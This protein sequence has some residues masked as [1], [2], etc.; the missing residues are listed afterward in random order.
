MQFQASE[1]IVDRVLDS[2]DGISD[3]KNGLIWHW[4]GSGKTLT[5][6][7]AANKLYHTK[8]LGNPSIFFI[9][10]RLDLKDQL[11]QEFTGLDV[12]RPEII[13]NI[14]E[15]KRIIQYDDYRGKKGVFITLIHKFRPEELDELSLDLKNL[16]ER[17]EENISTRK[18]VI[19]FIDEAHRT[20]YGTLAGQ[21]R[22]ILGGGFFFAFTGTPIAKKEKDTYQ[23]FAYLEEGENYLDRYFIT[24]S[25]KDGFTLKIV[26]QP[27]L[28]KDVHLDKKLIKAFSE[29]EF[30]ELPEKIRD[31]VE[32]KVKEKLN[33]INL[34]LENPRRIEIVAKDVAEHFTEN[35]DG[36]FKAMVVASS[37]KACVRY[38]RALDKLIPP[39][40]SE[41]VMTYNR[42][43]DPLIRGYKSELMERYHSEDVKEIKQEI[44]EKF[45][46]QDG[47]PKILIVTDM[48]LTG[49]DA[50]ILQT[51][52]LDKPLK[53]HR[54]LQAVA[55]TNRPY[56]DV[57][58]AGNILDYVG[59]IKEEL[60][61]ALEIYSAEEI[62][63][64]LY[65]ID[66]IIKDFNKLMDEILAL[67]ED[68]PKKQYNRET[69]LQAI[70]VLTSNDENGEK[71]TDNYLNLRRL[72]EFLGT[73]SIK[74]ERLE[75]FKW[76]TV[77]YVYYKKMVTRDPVLDETVRKYFKKTIKF[78]HKT[79]EFEEFQ[80]DLPVIEFDEHYLK[81]LEEKLNSEEE[82]AANI[83]FALNKLVLVKKQRDPV[84]ES[85]ADKV[86]RV[87]ELWKTRT[88]EYT[89]IS[90]L[91]TAI[92]Q[93]IFAGSKKKNDLGLSDMEFSILNVLE[94]RFGANEEFKTDVE[95]LS[96]KL[97]DDIFEGWIEQRS[98]HRKIE[99][100]V[101]R[102]L[103]RKYFKKYEMTMEDFED[104]Y[105]VVIEKVE[106]YAD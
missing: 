83:V 88:K 8:K 96:S 51:M 31:D 40:Y 87:L 19:T 65:D 13:G 95:D 46:E 49:F 25:I 103:R 43:D 47:P 11:Y 70:E 1:K 74:L 20:Q 41:V 75:E 17:G 62:E 33:A 104:L 59:M 42:K 38:K 90:T 85:V 92:I 18:N 94:E 26:Y 55:R 73:E 39:E 93:E 7:F 60:E 68:V 45:K 32:V 80:N 82:K 6:I 86:E 48:L 58:E 66:S 105:Q 99:G 64:A 35:I 9:V 50:P 2:L 3:K 89:K 24:D 69:L 12:V 16:T 14:D 98:V 81:N 102:F 15:L 4:Q 101:R 72:F 67:F 78:I 28:E 10:D 91:G 29:I 44:I 77:I 52:Y 36:K 106:N 76:I 34:F 56:K 53:E 100:I 54:L 63:N 71:F 21:M 61:R 27:R 57:K 22:S 97:S 23:Q 5:M 84:F 79:T 37:R 30:D